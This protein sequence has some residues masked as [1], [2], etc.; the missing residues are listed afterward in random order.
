MTLRF[1]EE[2][3]SR[4]LKRLPE[5]L[6]T[7]FA[8]AAVERLSLAYTKAQ[9]VGR[10]SAAIFGALI[11]RLWRDLQGEQMNEKELQEALE[12][13]SRL[14]SDNQ[15]SG[16]WQN[17]KDAADDAVTALCYAFRA[18]QT[19]SVQEAIWAARRVYEA[20]DNFVLN[21]AGIDTTVSMVEHFVLADPLI[22]AELARQRDDL[23]ALSDGSHAVQ[24]N[25]IKQIRQRAKS[26]ADEFFAS[27]R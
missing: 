7:A 26:N 2:E 27:P 25:L 10:S 19:G 22:Q 4:T 16:S 9:S 23:Q 6:R 24:A 17:E 8:T 12:T 14:I 3:M 15:S 21:R 18:R 13:C 20:L 5:S 11:D 1:D